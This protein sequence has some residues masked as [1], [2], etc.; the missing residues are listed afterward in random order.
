MSAS[1]LPFDTLSNDPVPDNT[2]RTYWDAYTDRNFGNNMGRRFPVKP[3][4]CAQIPPEERNIKCYQ[5]TKLDAKDK[6]WSNQTFTFVDGNEVRSG[7]YSSGRVPIGAWAATYNLDAPGNVCVDAYRDNTLYWGAFPRN[8]DPTLFPR[9]IPENIATDCAGGSNSIYEAPNFETIDDLVELSNGQTIRY[10]DIW[11][12]TTN[13]CFVGQESAVANVEGCLKGGVHYPTFCQLGDYVETVPECKQQCASS[14]TAFGEQDTYCHFAKDRLCGKQIGDRIKRDPNGN[15]VLSDKNWITEPV[16]IT[17]CGSPTEVTPS[18]RCNTAKKDFCRNPNSWPGICPDANQPDNICTP[19]YC[20]RYWDDDDRFNTQDIDEACA[21]KLLNSSSDENITTGYGCGKLCPGGFGDID[22]DYC[23]SK[24][25]QY[26]FSNEDNLFSN[27]CFDFCK[28]NPDLCVTNLRTYC[29]SIVDQNRTDGQINFDDLF[30]YLENT[31]AGE[32]KLKDYCG[33]FLPTAVYDEYTNKLE[34]QFNLLGFELDFTGYNATPNCMYPQCA[35]TTALK[36]VAQEN[37]VCASCLQSV[38]VSIN[39]STI[40][41]DL[42]ISQAAS[43]S[44]IQAQDPPATSGDPPAS[45]S[46]EPPASTSEEPPPSTTSE[47]PPSTTITRKEKQENDLKIL[48]IILG[49]LASIAVILGIAFLKSKTNFSAF[50]K[51][52]KEDENIFYD[53]LLRNIYETF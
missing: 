33:C 26:C 23:D 28:E 6:H 24:R 19:H 49:V 1:P 17:Y 51:N 11:P 34:E 45:T 21:D 41:G 22:K 29:D 25:V 42:A 9:R 43:C 44:R 10:D 48:Y 39:N 14:I 5:L 4:S 13:K 37:E 7:R 35:G 46:E 2:I 52:N 18:N 3:S 38:F 27:F 47:E 40:D 30:N 8:D 16:C 32:R 15:D 50:P 12:A 31:D 36:T 20:F 53:N